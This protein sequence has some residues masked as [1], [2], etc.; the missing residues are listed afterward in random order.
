MGHHALWHWR[1]EQSGPWGDYC[2]PKDRQVTGGVEGAAA[3]HPHLPISACL[4]LWSG[5][6][7]RDCGW[8]ALGYRP[9][10]M[11]TCGGSPSRGVASCWGLCQLQQR[12]ADVRET[13]SPLRG[14]G[15]RGLIP[16]WPSDPHPSGTPRG[17]AAVPAVPCLRQR[18]RSLRSSHLPGASHPPLPAQGNGRDAGDTASA[19]APPALCRC[20]PTHPACHRA[21][22]A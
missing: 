13:L 8:S 9:V 10:P 2:A 4:Q 1:E 18:C 20:L 12:L 15:G 21:P 14:G 6:W 16:A 5:G 19:R 11:C 3:P 17:L 7:V 22:A